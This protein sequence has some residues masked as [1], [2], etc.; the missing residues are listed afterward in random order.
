M[1]AGQYSQTLDHL[2]RRAEKAEA[3]RDEARA[4]A[5]AWCKKYEDSYVLVLRERDRAR[6]TIDQ[7]IAELQQ[8]DDGVVRLIGDAQDK[9]LTILRAEVESR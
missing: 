8:F 1:T 6:D 5:S 7:A 3:E 4:S 2:T 9:A